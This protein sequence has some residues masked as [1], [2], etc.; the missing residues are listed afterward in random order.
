MNIRIYVTGISNSLEA[1]E[2]EGAQVNYQA[3]SFNLRIN[4]TGV[5]KNISYT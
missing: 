1:Q 4:K 5:L 2:I 3:N